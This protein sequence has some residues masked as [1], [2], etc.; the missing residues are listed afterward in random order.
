MPSSTETDASGTAANTSSSAGAPRARRKTTPETVAL[1][2]LVIV[3][4]L[5]LLGP[6]LSPYATDVPSG[7]PYLEP[8]SGGH[9]LGTD[10]LGF[11]VLTRVLAGTR[12]SLFAA[13]VVTGGS[14][15]LGLLIGAVAGFVG[16]WVD[17]LLMRITDLFL[18]FPA[19]IVAMAIV[20]A[21]G[22]SLRSSM[23]GIA[24]VW[25]PLYARI[26][27]GEIRR[28]ATSLHVEAA[29]MSGTH[30]TRL[31]VRHTVPTVLPTVLVTASLDIG[32]VIMTLAALAFIGLGSPAPSPELGL[33]AGAGLQYL[34][35]SWW[36]PVFPAV[37]V[38]LLSLI[39]NYLG[40]GLRS[41]L[42]ARG[43]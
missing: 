42:R 41:V 27:R 31:M 37:A 18:A 19:T 26:A 22:P 20:A 23:I 8:F 2:A 12:I 14:A 29:R 15:L 10:N 16:G 6:L 7:T 9:W 28:A 25:W 30:G 21:L 32:G 3:V 34:L 1:A 24:I 38:G 39:F 40:D 33:M 11:D 13:L 36:I 43:A 4:L 35:D 5:A 17:S